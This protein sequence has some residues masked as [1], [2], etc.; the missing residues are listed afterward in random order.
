L[1]LE[2]FDFRVLRGGFFIETG[3]QFPLPLLKPLQH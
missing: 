2:R 3:L 1:F